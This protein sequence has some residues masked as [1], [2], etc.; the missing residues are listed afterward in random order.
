MARVVNI[1]V[2][3]ELLYTL[4]DGLDAIGPAPEGLR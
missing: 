2:C 1:P 4:L 3:R